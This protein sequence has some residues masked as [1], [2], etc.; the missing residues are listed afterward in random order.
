MISNLEKYKK[1]LNKLISRGEE[2]Y[3]AIGA[4]CYPEETQEKLKKISKNF[5]ADT[6]EKISKF[7]KKLPSFTHDYQEWYSESLTLLQQLLPNRVD[8]FISLYKKPKTARKNITSNN[9]VIEDALQ[10][11]NLTDRLGKKIVDQCTAIPL[12]LQ[13]VSILKSVKNRFQSSLFDIRKLVQADLFDSELETAKELNTKG[14]TRGAGGIAGVVLERHLLQVCDNHKVI[15]KKKNPTINNLAELL[16]NT[17]VIEISE[18]RRIQYLAD[19][20]NLCDH[21]KETTPTK[22]NVSELIKGVSK[23]VKTLF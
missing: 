6:K 7:I 13:Q 23:V 5:D 18:W 20:R 19:L 8:D 17:N 15:V 1:D 9:Y 4:E 14:F 12:L 11:L 16:K 10:G 3:M 21:K 2:L 22:E